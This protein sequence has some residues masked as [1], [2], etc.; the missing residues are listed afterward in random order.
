MPLTLEAPTWVSLEVFD[1]NGRRLA[2]P[3]PERL[4]AGI[5]EV[6]WNGADDHGRPVPSGIYFLRVRVGIET[7]TRKIV[8]RP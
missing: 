6:A 2:S 3:L 4:P 5:H 8:L 7:T 1:L